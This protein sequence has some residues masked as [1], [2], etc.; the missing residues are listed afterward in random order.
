MTIKELLNNIL[1]EQ[2]IIIEDYN[3]K[4]IYCINPCFIELFIE[5][6]EKID[7]LKDYKIFE[8]YCEDDKIHIKI[9]KY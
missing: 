5:D 4:E 9:F 7:I 3:G 2:L 1:I 8:L 6:S